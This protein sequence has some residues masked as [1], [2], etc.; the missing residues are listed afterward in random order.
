MDG[1]SD[2]AIRVCRRFT[3]AEP[4]LRL[5]VND[6]IGDTRKPEGEEICDWEVGGWETTLIAGRDGKAIPFCIRDVGWDIAVFLVGSN[7]FGFLECSGVH[8]VN[9]YVGCHI[10][11]QCNSSAAE[12]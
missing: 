5:G 11:G 4:K 8:Q 2:E 6:A 10:G 3:R 1:S 7:P 12:S 9:E